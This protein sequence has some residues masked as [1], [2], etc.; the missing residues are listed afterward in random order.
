MHTYS[1][2]S[3]I[4]L[5][6]ARAD[7]LTRIGQGEPA[8]GDLKRAWALAGRVGDERK[9]KRLEL[10]VLRERLGAQYML[11]RLEDLEAT[12]E[13]GLE[14][15]RALEDRAWEAVFLNTTCVVRWHQGD[16]RKALDSSLRSLQIRQELNDLQ[17]QA[18][19]LITVG[20]CYFSLGQTHQALESFQCALTL[21][22]KTENPSGE[23]VA[24]N[25]I[26]ETFAALGDPEQALEAYRS[27]LALRERIGDPQGMADTVC[28]LGELYE[29]MGEHKEARTCQDRAL[30]ISR[31]IGDRLREAR[32]LYNIGA[33][34]QALGEE[35]EASSAFR[36]ALEITRCLG[37]HSSGLEELILKGLGRA[38]LEKGN[39]PEAEEALLQAEALARVWGNRD[40]LAVILAEIAA[41]HLEGGQAELARERIRQ[42]HQIAEKLSSKEHKARG[43]CLE[44]RLDILLG[45]KGPARKAFEDSLPLFKELRLE[46]ELGQACYHFG[47][48]LIGIGEPREGDW[49]LVQAR[50]IFTRLG[51]KSWLRKLDVS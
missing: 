22:R 8:L 37:D 28:N 1:L 7:L 11:S 23:A 33:L 29:K 34:N 19:C 42:L 20:T 40:S 43:L 14:R 12:A 31:E 26:G 3:L 41:Y 46:L 51:A 15:A 9:Q 18:K 4:Q 21:H 48:G 49:Y 44:G 47:R 27:S 38:W 45:E 6:C 39:R 25:N 32:V 30:A 36:K 50:E 17:G 16:Y 5:L 35:E 2:P 10:D 13:Q 24:L